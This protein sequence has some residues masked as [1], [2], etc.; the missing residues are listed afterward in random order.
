MQA[1]KVYFKYLSS[2]KMAHTK[3]TV[4]R[5]TERGN[6]SIPQPQPSTSTSPSQPRIKTAVGKMPQLGKQIKKI[7]T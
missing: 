1:W 2:Q 4:K 7:E 3:S 6:K 5:R